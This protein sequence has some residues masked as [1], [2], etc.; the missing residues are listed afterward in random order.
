MSFPQ[1]APLYP[2]SHPR[3]PAD[4]PLPGRTIELT[5][6]CSD[7]LDDY[8]TPTFT[9]RPG[10]IV[11]IGRASKN[12]AKPE[13]MI[14]PGNAFIDSPTISREH[15]V[16]SA[17]SPPD[18]AVYITDKG[19]MHG[20]MVNGEKLDPNTSRR[21]GNGDVLQFGANVTRENRMYPSFTSALCQGSECSPG[22]QGEPHAGRPLPHHDTPSQET[23][24]LMHIQSFTLPAPSLSSHPCLRTPRAFLCLS[25]HPTTKRS[26]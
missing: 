25:I 9:L 16:L 23:S 4:L 14:G 5:L 22:T 10:A 8:N 15:A 26:R 19:S 6:R 24:M 18:S 13:L 20:T 3:Q 2:L 7:K 1:T 17:T 21:L 11:Q 12:T